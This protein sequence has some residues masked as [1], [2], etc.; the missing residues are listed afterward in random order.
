MPMRLDDRL[1]AR[2]PSLCDERNGKALFVWGE[3]GQWLVLDAEAALLLK[4]FDRERSVADVLQEYSR[5]VGK[6]FEATAREALP[7]LDAIMERGILGSPPPEPQPLTDPLRI[8]NLTFNI[9]N[10]CNLKCIWCYNQQSAGNEITVPVLLNWMRTGIASLDSDAA[11]IILGGEPF[12]DERRLLDCVR[13]VRKLMSG[14]ILV[15]TNGTILDNQTPLALARANATVQ[16]SLDSAS[17]A[18]HDSIRGTGV[19]QRAIE[20]AR[21]LA[22]SGVRTIL[23]MVMTQLAE[24]EL[25]AY[26]DL[27]V[28]IGVNEVRFIP[29]RRIGRGVANADAAPDLFVCFRRLVE[30]LRRRPELSRLLQR[31]F[32]SIL[33]TACRFSRLRGNCGIG[34]RCLFLDADGSI[35][36]CPNHRG[37]E[38]RCGHVLN[39]PL[40]GILDTSATLESMRAQYRLETMTTC[41]RCPFC[42]WCAGDCRAEVLATT[43]E[44]SGPSPYCHALK[45]IMKDAFWLIAEGWQGLAS[46]DRDI[47]PWS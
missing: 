3:L 39:T 23:S 43:G 14:E 44:P 41:C 32:F 47:Q 34:R 37:P 21:R 38:F 18:K 4:Y 15:S 46:Q 27:G 31:D 17:P 7:L 11:F 10:R 29:M 1:Q 20:S 5:T 36:P 28:K 30:I 26:L 13:G 2:P 33:M 25:E 8:S 16:V 19:F 22:D 35:F 42:H 6:P 12:L 24:E 40:T 45:K 9:T